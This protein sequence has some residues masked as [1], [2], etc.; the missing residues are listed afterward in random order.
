MTLKERS[1]VKFGNFSEFYPPDFLS[2]M[3]NITAKV[4]SG[5]DELGLIWGPKSFQWAN[6]LK[7]AFRRKSELD[8][9]LA[10]VNAVC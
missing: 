10:R 8:F 2:S 7:I 1:K 4:H 6:F 3:Q 9:L 5:E